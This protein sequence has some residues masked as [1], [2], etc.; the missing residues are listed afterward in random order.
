MKKILV[1]VN[2][3]NLKTSLIDFSSYLARLTESP[4]T[5]LLIP[6]KQAGPLTHKQFAVENDNGHGHIVSSDWREEFPKS[7]SS[8]KEL[9][10]NRGIHSETLSRLVI[11]V[12]DLIRE[13]RYAD[14]LVVDAEIS[15]RDELQAIPGAT[16]K[17]ILSESE[18]PVIVA[19]EN[20]DWVNQIIFAYDGNSSSVHAMKQFTY[21]F[22]EFKNR[23]VMVLQV[24][25]E[26][27]GVITEKQKISAW[28]KTH[29][30]GVSFRTL[31]GRP[32]DELFGYLLEKEK[33]I[34]VMGAFGRSMISSLFSSS[35]AELVLKS[36]NLPI[37]ICH[38]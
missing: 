20:F 7:V 31:M 21:L 9:C 19:P 36:V 14:L 37:F 6:A 32:K 22:P 35:K 4:L 38:K 8:F 12:D 25:E 3:S 24:C 30:S 2:A 16:L 26:K 10:S 33:M 29:Y 34:V 23:E 5:G 11:S 28:L 18:C 17:K 1:A 27:A 13:T 15:F